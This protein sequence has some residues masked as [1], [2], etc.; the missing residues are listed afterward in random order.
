MERQVAV[1]L[2]ETDVVYTNYRTAANLVFFR[3]GQLSPSNA[4]TIPYEELDPRNMPKGAYVLVNRGMGEFLRTYYKYEVPEFAAK[5]P[6]VW[7]RRW[8]DGNADLYL[9]GGE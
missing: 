2:Q 8:S 7:K 3:T 4:T 6:S 9:V 5:P 1:M